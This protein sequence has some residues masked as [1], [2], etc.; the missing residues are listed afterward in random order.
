[1]PL[2]QA[3]GELAGSPRLARRNLLLLSATAIA[4][5]LL[6]AALGIAGIALTA[7]ALTQANVAAG[8]LR[9]HGEV[10]RMHDVLRADVLAAATGS[11]SARAD[12]EQHAQ[13]LQ[14]MLA[15]LEATRLPA[16]VH[17]EMAQEAAA[18][19]GY[20][21][22]GRELV[23]RMPV[24]LTD[25]HAF[26]QRSRS[27]Q[28]QQT[29][30]S[31][32]LRAL[33]A[34]AE[35]NGRERHRDGLL[36]MLLAFAA[37]LA[38]VAVTATRLSRAVFASNRQL[39]ELTDRAVQADRSRTE[40]LANM[41]HEIRTPMTG[42]L[43]MLDLLASEDLPPQQRRYVASMRSSGQHL[44]AVIN[45]ILD[46]TRIE[47]GRLTLE[48][49]DFSLPK[50][51]EQLRSLVNPLAVERGLDLSVELAPHSP[52]VLRGDPTRLRQVL[53]NLCTNAVKFTERGAV[54]VHAAALQHRGGTWRFRFEVIDTG[55]GIA[56][57]AMPQLFS[58]FRQADQSITRR[59]GG[60]GL[61]L[62]ICKRLVEAMGGEIGAQSQLG[63]GSVFHFEL[64]LPVGDAEGVSGPMPLQ[65]PALAPRRIL[66]AEDVEVNR[67]ILR[68]GLGRVGHDVVFACDGAE[69]V[70]LAERE[71]FD[72]VLMDV[73]MPVMDGIEATRRIRRLANGN[74]RI[75]VL[76]LTANVMAQ[77][78]ERYFAAG[79]DD[80]LTKPIDWDHLLHA[81]A[82]YGERSGSAR[83]NPD[84]ADAGSGPA[85][86]AQGNEAA[87][88]T[89][90]GAPP[91]AAADLP[92]LVDD[93]AQARLVE[94]ASREHLA[95]WLELGLASYDSGCAAIAAAAA[96]ANIARSEAHRIKGS[97]GTLGL[98]RLQVA[99][100]D[101]ERSAEAGA[102]PVAHVAALQQ[103]LADT[104]AALRERGLLAA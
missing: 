56:A 84:A 59:F 29:A 66:V 54:R 17:D 7:R 95:E 37:M 78:R 36:L 30:V 45:D 51:L 9:A 64:E 97:A 19:R 102:V 65:E 28:P 6:T 2:R 75:P 8:A 87:A 73:H 71:R 23:A 15:E 48:E 24:P 21:E 81:I 47:T 79:M 94:M 100:A 32:Q 96:D 92:P 70:Q 38:A 50:L 25:L 77:E 88:A 35:A 1:M 72:L 39:L 53:L 41:S 57:E 99:A 69:A 90:A 12:F 103:A 49:V 55:V 104:R 34:T 76:A 46:F 13:L 61:G 3:L 67:E 93:A 31:D 40:F 26:V 68:R 5:M 10:D 43:G 18:L 86:A 20:V 60:S 42:V 62:A 91:D 63:V 58:A 44:L 14:R 52:P 27:L 22:N 85:D 101:L 82:R 11:V 16:A 89:A 98:A 83:V 33:V 4:G 80:C 74:A